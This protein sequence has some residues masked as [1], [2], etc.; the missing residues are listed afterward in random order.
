MKKTIKETIQFK[1]VQSL[2]AEVSEL[3]EKKDDLSSQFSQLQKEVQRLK[4]ER[5]I[6]K[7]AAELIKKDLGINLQT[8]TNREKAIII[9]AL[10]ESHQLNELLEIIYM[11]KSSSA[12]R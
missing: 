11:A 2:E 9:N 5:D 10:R 8:L 7:K 1:N 3:H 6:Y 4:I 12:I